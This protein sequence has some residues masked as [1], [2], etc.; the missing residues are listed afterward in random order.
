MIS[1]T[2]EYSFNTVAFG[3]RKWPFGVNFGQFNGF[4]SYYWAVVTI[5]ILALTAVNRYF[6]EVKPR[7]YSS[8]FT[9]KKT[10]FLMLF[11]LLFTLTVSLTITLVTPVMLRWHY[12]YLFCQLKDVQDL[13]QNRGTT[14]SLVIGFVA[15]PMYLI[16]F[17]Y[18]SVYLVIRQHNFVFVPSLQD[19]NG[20]GTLSEHEIQASR[21]LLAAVIAFCVCWI[22]A[23]VVGVLEGIARITVSSFWQSANTLAAAYSAWINPII[24][25]VMNRAMRKESLKL[26]RCRKES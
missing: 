19:A 22:P 13:A 4:F 15:L 7:S 9:K 18:G 24:Y 25:G 6:C 26:L 21:V 1:A 8:F 23:T 2:F 12:H 5:G 20:Q 16:L 17:C 11:V 3:L 14:I 10:V